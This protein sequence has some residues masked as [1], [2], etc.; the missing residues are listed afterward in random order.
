MT[1]MVQKEDS[2]EVPKCGLKD[3]GKY[4]LYC[5]YCPNLLMEI[6]VVRPDFKLPDG[7]QYSFKYKA[8]CPFCTGESEIKEIKGQI[9]FLDIRKENANGVEERVTTIGDV[10][11]DEENGICVI[12][13]LKPKK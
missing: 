9:V 12:K 4:Q 6:W 10:D 2:P 5:K 13:V 11:A 1:V 8:T 3:G 7:S